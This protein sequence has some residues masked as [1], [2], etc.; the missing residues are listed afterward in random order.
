[1]PSGNNGPTLPADLSGANLRIGVIRAGW[2]EGVVNRLADGVEKA[3]DR[4]QVKNATWVSVPGCLEIPLAAQL[5]ARSG[6]FD[7]L[8]AIGAVIR[9]ETTHYEL[10]SEG[11][12]TGVLRVQLDTGLPIGFGVV[13]VED[14]E[15]AM[16]RSEANGGHN[17]GDEATEVAVQMALIARD[18]NSTI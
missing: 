16:A 5:L 3:L 12:A 4:L 15:Q 13:T 2:N 1:M 9:G 18:W 6:D 14:H 11:S 8:V 7:A 10:V 17:V